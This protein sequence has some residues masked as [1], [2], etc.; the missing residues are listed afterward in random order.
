MGVS[1]RVWDSGTGRVR[2]VPFFSLFGLVVELASG[3]K[4]GSHS[5][6]L[7]S[8]VGLRHVLGVIDGMKCV[9]WAIVSLNGSSCKGIWGCARVLVGGCLA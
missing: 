1:E 5:C 8:A 7:S 2:L 3:A 6:F 4:V 9:A